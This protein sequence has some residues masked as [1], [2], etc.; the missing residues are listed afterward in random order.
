MLRLI[1]GDQVKPAGK[2]SKSKIF[3]QLGFICSAS[4]S[5]AAVLSSGVR[6]SLLQPYAPYV[7]QCCCNRRLTCCYRSSQLSAAVEKVPL[8][9]DFLNKGT[10]LNA[11]GEECGFTVDVTV[12]QPKPPSPGPEN[13]STCNTF[14]LQSTYKLHAQMSR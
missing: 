5:T 6:L 8:K 2:N 1:A 3:P 13:P 14:L 12:L 9:A 7:G 10:T 11:Y 4:I